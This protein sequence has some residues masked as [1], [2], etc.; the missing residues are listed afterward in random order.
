MA[1]ANFAAS[2]FSGVSHV[3]AWSPV[4]RLVAFALN[5]NAKANS[6]N[7]EIFLIMIKDYVI[8]IV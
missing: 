1:S 6:I 2:K 5:K 8:N 7:K 4:N 3:T